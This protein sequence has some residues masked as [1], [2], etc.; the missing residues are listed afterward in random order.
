[1]KFLRQESSGPHS[2]P[3]LALAPRDASISYLQVV[4]L[5]GLPL[6][7]GAALGRHLEQPLNLLVQRTVEVGTDHQVVLLCKLLNLVLHN[8]I[9]LTHSLRSLLHGLFVSLVYMACLPVCMVP[10][11]TTPS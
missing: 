2:V 7:L 6:V 1:V 4:G 3:Q 11:H 5:Q 9:H 10:Q 8:V